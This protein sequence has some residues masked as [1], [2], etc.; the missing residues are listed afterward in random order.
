[1]RSM[2]RIVLHLEKQLLKTKSAAHLLFVVQVPKI[3]N[4]I[5]APPGDMFFLRFEDIFSLF[6]L[7]QLYHTIGHRV[8]LSLAA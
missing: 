1:M 2:H 7:K 8:V 3:M 6:L 4:F 5:T